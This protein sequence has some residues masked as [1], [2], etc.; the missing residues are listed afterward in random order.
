MCV[1]REQ[2]A[3]HTFVAAAPAILERCPDAVLAVIG[4]GELKD[5]LRQQATD[6]DLGDRFA[7]FPFRQPSSRQ[8][9]WVDVLVLSSSWG[10]LSDLDPRGDGLRSAA[11]RVHVGGTDE[12]VLDGETGYLCAPEDSEAL[13]ERTSHL[14][15]DGELRERMGRAAKARYGRRELPVPRRW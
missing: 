8:L 15:L 5:A 2:K 11:S 1:L 14:L 13:A 12:A 9:A 7:F 10:S 4:D 3:V 6:L